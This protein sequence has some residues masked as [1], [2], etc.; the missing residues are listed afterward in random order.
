MNLN[1]LFW[2]N[3][4][5]EIGQRMKATGPINSILWCIT[6]PH[7]SSRPLCTFCLYPL[8]YSLIILSGVRVHVAN[9]AQRLSLRMAKRFAQCWHSPWLCPAT[10]IY[11]NYYNSLIFFF[12]FSVSSFS[13]MHTQS[14]KQKQLFGRHFSMGTFHLPLAAP[15][16]EGSV[17]YCCRSRPVCAWLRPRPIHYNQLHATCVD[18]KYFS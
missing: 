1:P 17:P 16:T 18:C 7:H 13:V 9:C 5:K 8:C 10:L 11:A 15:E 14:N 12:F 6:L 2:V 4:L 3:E